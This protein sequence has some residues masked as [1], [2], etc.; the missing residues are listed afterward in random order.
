M[1]SKEAYLYFFD[2]DNSSMQHCLGVT[3]ITRETS[4]T[5]LQLRKTICSAML[6]CHVLDARCKVKK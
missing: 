2:S 5:S 6:H 1:F 3:S 4:E